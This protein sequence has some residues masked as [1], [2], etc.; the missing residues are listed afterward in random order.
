[1]SDSS[2]GRLLRLRSE[3]AA[4]AR[5]PL[6]IQMRAREIAQFFQESSGVPFLTRY[7]VAPAAAGSCP[8]QSL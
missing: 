6:H 5:A 2:Q 4:N 7:L 1:V 8:S 3:A